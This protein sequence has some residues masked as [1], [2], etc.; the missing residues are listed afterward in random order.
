[1]KK[2]A[3]AALLLSLVG[4][5]TQRF[6]VRSDVQNA[7]THDNS[8]SFW[9]GGIGQSEELDAAKVCGGAAKVQRVETQLTSGNIGLTILTLGIYSP[10]QVRVYCTR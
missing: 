1:M 4:C 9:V 3:I 2:I 10:R 7:P 5:A 8:Q 6:D